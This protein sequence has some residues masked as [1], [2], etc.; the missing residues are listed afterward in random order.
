MKKHKTLRNRRKIT[1]PTTGKPVIRTPG[2]PPMP[3]LPRQ[4]RIV[5]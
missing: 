5:P 4:W 3:T 2:K 1:G